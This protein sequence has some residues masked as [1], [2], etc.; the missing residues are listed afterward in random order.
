MALRRG[1]RAV[2][3]EGACEESRDGVDE[4][5]PAGAAAAA[6]GRGT[7]AGQALQ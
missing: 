7:A 6:I 5:R 4:L 1:T 3:N 2:G